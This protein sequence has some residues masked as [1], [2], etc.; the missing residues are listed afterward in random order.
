MKN[1]ITKISDFLNKYKYNDD[2][3]NMNIIKVDNDIINTSQ[4]V[5][6]Y[7][8]V[9]Q[10]IC[11]DVDRSINLTKYVKDELTQL[12]GKN[13]TR[14]KGEY[15]Y[16]VWIVEFEGEIFQIFTDKSKGTQYC[17]VANYEDDKSKVCINFLRKIEEMFDSLK[18]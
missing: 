10:F 4:S 18:K 11:D 15:F 12:F 13:N 14:F 2:L 16:Y 9:L 6:N 17:I 3:T 7:K 5:E 1:I 8:N